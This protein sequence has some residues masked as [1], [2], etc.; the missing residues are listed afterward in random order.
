M[1][2][3]DGIP[4]R[5]PMK[6]DGHAVE[7]AEAPAVAAPVAAPGPGPVAQVL[8]LQAS[9]GNRAVARALAARR[10]LARQ[11]APA[12]PARTAQQL[13][14]L[15]EDITQA[16]AEKETHRTAVESTMRTSA[17]VRAS[18]ASQ[19]QATAGW[20][21][22][23]LQAL[24]DTRLAAFG[25]TRAELRDANARAVA[26]DNV[27]DAVMATPVATTAATFMTTNAT[28]IAA[29]GLLRADVDRM[30]LFRDLR[31]DLESRLTTEVPARTTALQAL[32]PADV[33]ALATAA[34][35]RQV[36]AVKVAQMN[37]ARRD[38]LAPVI[39]RREAVAAVAAGAP[40]TT[41]GIPAGTINAYRPVRGGS[42]YAEDKVAWQ[43]VAVGR[44]PAGGTGTV[45]SRLETA[46]TAD[47]GLQLG[48][49]RIARIN[50]QFLA[51]NPA[52]T[53]DQVCDNAARRHNPGNP[54]I[55]AVRGHFHTFQAARGAAATPAG[56]AAPAGGTA[57]APAGG[58]APTPAAA[59]G[60]TGALDTSGESD[61][62]VATA[63][64][65]VESDAGGAGEQVAAAEIRRPAPLSEEEVL[66]QFGLA[67]PG[68]PAAEAAEPTLAAKRLAR[69]P[70]TPAAP[71]PVPAGGAPAS[72]TQNIANPTATPTASARTGGSDEEWFDEVVRDNLG[73]TP[74][75]GVDPYDWLT[76]TFVTVNVFGVTSGPVM[77]R[78]AAKLQRASARAEQMIRDRLT[79]AGTTVTGALTREQWNVGSVSGWDAGRRRGSHAFGQATDIDYFENP[80]VAH[81]AG[82]AEQRVDAQTG[83]AYDRAVMLFGDGQRILS[84]IPNEAVGTG[85]DR[86]QRPDRITN[87]TRPGGSGATGRAALYDQTLTVYNQLA[88]DS[89]AMQRYFALVYPAPDLTTSTPTAATPHDVDAAAARALLP[90]LRALP[91]AALARVFGGR[92]P[93]PLDEA[94][95]A[96]ALRPII[97][98]DY[99]RLGGTATNA[100]T[101]GD[102]PFATRG[103]DAQRAQRD[104]RRGFMTLP[105]EVV[106][107]LR[108]EGL[109]WGACDLGGASGDIQHFDDGAAHRIPQRT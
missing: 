96:A 83:P 45:G 72:A 33:W 13:A 81:E 50:E 74:P 97:E 86:I 53:D 84:V 103:S 14:D 95:V 104:P 17:G 7:T 90:R 15:N 106:F 59:P 68:P 93:D 88:S 87:T 76:S 108:A 57:P 91:P 20:T 60:P 105:F 18:Y 69:V 43:R 2:G 73:V 70:S 64:P 21:I 25:L 71:V 35:R 51:A 30:F 34:E 39:A 10:A 6:L 99:E 109:R 44:E 22:S 82:E 49:A 26:A 66:A 3:K 101:S 31:A 28:Q 5:R 40:A 75:A 65:A 107:S 100:G 63:G 85:A 55:A 38:R 9:A 56:G 36:G 8:G 79:A 78:F 58:P 23:A 54:M 1:A 19:V 61:T 52:A 27:W 29:A 32:P 42:N 80:Y 24:D 92:A 11:P 37:A 47:G 102:R 46:A 62:Q 12:P 4:Y 94:S 67:D 16:I 98:R 77:P 41:L 89:T 48:R